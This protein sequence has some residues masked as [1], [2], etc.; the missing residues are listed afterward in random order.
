MWVEKK[1]MLECVSHKSIFLHIQGLNYKEN[2][3]ELEN[4]VG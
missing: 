3:Y 2:A 4:H 1:I